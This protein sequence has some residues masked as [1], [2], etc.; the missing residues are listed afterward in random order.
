MALHVFEPQAYHNTLASHQPVLKIDPGDSILTTTV[1]ARGYDSKNEFCG[2]SGNP[3][4]GPFFVRGAAPGDTLVVRIERLWPNRDS[5]FTRT[6]IAPNVMDFGYTPNF[7]SSVNTANWTLDLA[8]GLAHLS[9]PRNRVSDLKLPIKPMLGC[10][11]VAPDGDQAISTATSAAHGGN[12]DYRGIVE[13]VTIYLPVFVT[14]ALFHLGDGHAIQGDGEI[15][16]SGIETSMDVTFTLSLLRQ[17]PI[18]WPRAEDEQFIMAMGNARPL[19][20][21]VQHATTELVRW[22]RVD[23]GLTE[24]EIHL[25]LGQCIRYDIGNI[26][27]PAYTMVA[28]I[29]KKLLPNIN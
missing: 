22:L 9:S 27:D 5:G 8:T 20:Q 14:G 18:G 26:F 28:K 17:P 11:G 25:L 1:D 7:E 10:F 6:Q 29:E 13:G 24:R 12:M 21:A 3:Q 2:V 4:T 19:D 23:Y 15:V 16:G